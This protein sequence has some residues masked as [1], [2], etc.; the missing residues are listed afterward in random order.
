MKREG[1]SKP[2]CPNP[3]GLPGRDL[4]EGESAGLGATEDLNSNGRENYAI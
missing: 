4:R 3:A 2:P 1:E